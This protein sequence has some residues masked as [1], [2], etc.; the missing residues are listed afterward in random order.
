MRRRWG[1]GEPA[2]GDILLA[3]AWWAARRADSFVGAERHAARPGERAGRTCKQLKDRLG[4]RA[5]RHQ[6][7][8]GCPLGAE[9][10]GTQVTKEELIDHRQHDRARARRARP[11]SGFGVSARPRWPAARPRRRGE[12]RRKRK[13]DRVRRGAS[14]V[15]DQN[16]VIKVDPSSPTSASAD[17]VDGA[18]A[19]CWKRSQ[20]RRRVGRERL[21]R[22][23]QGGRQVASF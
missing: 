15:G 18:P 5:R 3:R 8:R 4:I 1:T 12:P 7:Y 23:R 16:Q 14:D 19:P 21:G 9:L 6:G 2:V 11:P 20:G 10:G 17:M 13:S 22:G